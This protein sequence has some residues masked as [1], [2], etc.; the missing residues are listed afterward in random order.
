M[1]NKI[2]ICDDEPSIRQLLKYNLVKSNYAVSEAVSAEEALLKID[3]EHFDL[4]ILDIMLPDMDG[5]ELC[6]IIQQKYATPIIFLSA[7]DSEVDKIVGL[8][9]GGD[10]YLS[11]PFS[12]RELLARVKAVLRRVETKPKSR[13][14]HYNS[15]VIG[16]VVIDIDG[17]RVLKNNKEITL[18]SLEYELLVFL[19]KNKGKA[20]HRHE[21]MDNVWGTTFVGDTRI[22][23]V[24]VSHLRDKL[25]LEKDMDGYIETVRGIGYRLR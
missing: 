20:L 14:R 3:K 8:E 23:D 19:A 2:L 13:M 7:K 15:L 11:K 17:R 12:V 5:L 4:L 9:L 16:Q 10:D 21:I 25:N 1:K 24:H 18:T 22:I 6:G